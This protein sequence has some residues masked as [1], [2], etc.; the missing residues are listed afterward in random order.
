MIESNPYIVNCESSTFSVLFNY[1]NWKKEIK[2]IHG[3]MQYPDWQPNIN[4]FNYVTDL[5]RLKKDP[6]TY[7]VFDAS[8]EGFSPFKNFFFHNLYESCRLHNVPPEKIIF[9]STNMKD[10]HNLET[11]KRQ[12]KLK[13]SIKVFPFLSF[14]KMIQDLTEDTY[15]FDFDCDT[16]FDHFRSECERQYSSKFGLS[17]SRVNRQHRT[18]ANYLL[19]RNKLEL[20]FKVSQAQLE[21]TEIEDTKNLYHLNDDF[22]DWCGSLPKT[23]DTLDFKTN[24]ALTLNSHLHNS[25][26]FQIINETHAKDWQGTSL[27]YSEK[28]F[29]SMAHM[30]PFVIFGQPGCNTALENLGFRLFHEDFDYGFDHIQNTKSRY[31][32]ILNTCSDLI[33]QL[34]NMSRQEQ[35]NWRFSREEILKHNYRLVMDIDY[36]KTDFENLIEKL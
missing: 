25:T 7:F 32:A 17:L 16:A 34:S 19:S 27:F 8:T 26:L 2:L 33:Q 29:R 13:R 18:L 3:L 14:K 22:E 4:F 20:Y 21:N 11:Y 9:V 5:E 1:F 12:R 36:F 23:I 24:H 10:L 28:T 15:G 6:S 31:E 35:I 30:Q